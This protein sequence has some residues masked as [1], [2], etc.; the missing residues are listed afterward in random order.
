[1]SIFSGS[2]FN[3]YTRLAGG[4]LWLIAAQPGWAAG[5]AAGTS[6]SNSATLTY[7]TSTSIPATTTSNI[8]S[9]LVDQKINLLV[10]EV[11]G[12]ATSVSAGQTRA[13]TTFS[14]TNL[15]NAP[16]GF[17]LTAALALANP[18]GPP[19]FSTNNFSATGLVAYADS[20]NNGIY[21]PLTDTATSI[22]VLAADTSRK[23]FVV[24]DIPTTV[25][26]NQQSVVSLTATATA[27]ATMA[28]LVATPGPDTAGVDFVF[29]DI[30]GASPGDIARDAKHSAYAAY[31]SSGA[32]L[33]LN[34]SV[35]SVLDPIGS[36]TLMPGAVITYQIVATLAGSGTAN[37][38]VITDPLPANTT[39]LPGSITVNNIAKTDAADADN[40]QFIT[41]GQT[42]VVSLG[43][44]ASPANFLITFRATIN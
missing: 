9:F 33:T 10:V 29:A 18:A 7:T 28:A 19:P 35:A 31:L 26:S 42:L 34:K 32:G 21:E 11:T 27:P 20:N 1:M 37:N 39:Y 36:A 4:V 43:N 41:V 17:N 24:G 38:I 30:A 14:V 5:T 3:F 44:V 40:A 22:S 12:S 23:V 8:A 13:V 16:Q 6:I 25:L 15:G 2:K